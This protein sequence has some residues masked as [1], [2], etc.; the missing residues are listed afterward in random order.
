MRVLLVQQFFEGFVPITA[1]HAIMFERV[2]GLEFQQIGLLFSLWG[3]AFL[4]GELPSGV[5]ADYWSRKKVIML[6]GLLRAAGLTIWMVWPGFMGYAVGFVLWGGMIAC[7]SGAVSAYLH[8]ELRVV[9]QGKQYSKYF[10]WIASAYWLGMLLGFVAA[11]IFT[12]EHTNLLIGLGVASSVLFTGVLALVPEQPYKKQDTYLKT[13]A[14]GFREIKASKKLRYVCYGL[15]TVYMI[16]GVLEELLPRVYAGFG[17]TERAISLVLAVSLLLTVFLLTRLESFVRFSLAKQML[18]LALGM[19]FLLGGLYAGGNAGSLLILIFSLVFLLFRPIFQHHVQAEAKG[20]ERAT[21]GSI[22][23]LGG[24]LLGA[25]AYV[26][27]GKGAELSSEKVSMAIYGMF[28]FLVLLL[29]AFM[30]RGYV[31]VA[32]EAVGMPDPGQP[33]I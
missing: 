15:F 24:G 14:A 7:T 17:L 1:L 23:G 27:L 33:K 3:L 20:E 25:A 10:G 29:L 8:N 2:G 12:L 9:H 21:I 22:P 11:A 28:W 26:V 5:L 30:G 13:L 4:V 18:C 6:G 31:S 19:V 16:I 32:E